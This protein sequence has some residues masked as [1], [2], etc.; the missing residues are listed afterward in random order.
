MV[1][2]DETQF[3]YLTPLLPFDVALIIKVIAD[4]P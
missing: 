3:K 4:M 2:A 1:L